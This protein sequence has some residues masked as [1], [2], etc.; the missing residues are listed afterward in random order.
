MVQKVGY[1][2][3]D[4]A[5]SMDFTR[6]VNYLKSKKIP[7]LF[8]CRG[9]Y[10]EKRKDFAIDAIE[11]GFILGN[12]SFNHPHFSQL[13]L[14]ECQEQIQKTDEIIEQIYKDA[15]VQRPG[16]F[17]RFPF[18]DKGGDKDA[19]LGWSEDHR[20]HIQA[21]QNLLR[22]EGYYQPKFENITY[23]WYNTA[24]LNQ[25]ADV[26]WTYYTFD[27]EVTSDQK[28][29]VTNSLGYHDL[30]SLFARMDENVPE[31]CRGLNFSGSNDIIL[32]HDYLGIEDMFI[33]LIEA[34]ITKGIRFKLPKFSL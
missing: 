9:D 31:G 24:G 33:P 26:Y 7:A 11:Q 8:F 13:S 23:H 14:I 27:C 3:I 2:T 19:E 30:D 18:G 29:G 28:E 16:K 5:P 25:D 34:L 15:G 12:H 1:L 22:K 32:I 4:D 20:C 17:F 10:L 6:K 21:I